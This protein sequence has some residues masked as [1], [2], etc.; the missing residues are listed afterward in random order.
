MIL[1]KEMNRVENRLKTLGSNINE[2]GNVYKNFVE[3]KIKEDFDKLLQLR[4]LK[5]N[6]IVDYEKI[7]IQYFIYTRYFVIEN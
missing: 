2:F 6:D 3:D 5:K 1:K 4:E 7:F